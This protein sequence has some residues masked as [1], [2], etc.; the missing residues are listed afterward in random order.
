MADPII[1]PPLASPAAAP[2]ATGVVPVLTPDGK[3]TTVPAAQLVQPDS[4]EPATCE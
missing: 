1:A 4:V 2:V 3:V